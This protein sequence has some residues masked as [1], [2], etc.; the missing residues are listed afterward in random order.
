MGLWLISEYWSIPCNPHAYI[1]DCG[2]IDFGA[3]K[4]MRFSI[5]IIA[6]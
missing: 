5:I 4:T 2:L 3:E 6:N 1:Y